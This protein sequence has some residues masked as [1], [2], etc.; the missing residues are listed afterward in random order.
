M[1]N[2]RSIINWPPHKIRLSRH[3][4]T[5]RTTTPRVGYSVFTVDNQS[6][7]LSDFVLVQWGVKPPLHAF[8]NTAG[9]Q[10]QVLQGRILCVGRQCTAAGGAAKAEL[11][12]REAAAEAMEM[13]VETRA[14]LRGPLLLPVDPENI[15]PAR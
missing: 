14:A 3:A 11:V 15:A 8:T 6:T 10:T 1:K 5:S 7:L 12:E 4:R 9:S 2:R 13:A